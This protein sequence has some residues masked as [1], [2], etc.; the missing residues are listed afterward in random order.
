[1]NLYRAT[2]DDTV[3]SCQETVLIAFR[4]VGDALASL[5]TLSWDVEQQRAAVAAGQAV[6]GKPPCG[7]KLASIRI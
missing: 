6:Y 1:M 2:Y 4:Q 5:S 7:I 3:A